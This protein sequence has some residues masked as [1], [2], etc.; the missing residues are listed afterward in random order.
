MNDTYIYVRVA[1]PTDNEL[2]SEVPLMVEEI[3]V[4]IRI[5]KIFI[6]YFYKIL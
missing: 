2:T 4:N 6:F 1:L 5:F 3:E